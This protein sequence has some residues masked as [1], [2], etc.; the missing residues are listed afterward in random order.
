MA[1]RPLGRVGHQKYGV[2]TFGNGILHLRCH[3]EGNRVKVRTAGGGRLSQISFDF[4]AKN[5]NGFFPNRFL[6]TIIQAGVVDPTLV[7]QK[8]LHWSQRVS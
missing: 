5:P 4:R 2:K 1:V 8:A 7:L 3:G 6:G